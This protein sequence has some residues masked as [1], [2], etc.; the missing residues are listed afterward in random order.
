MEN[1]QA[2]SRARENK[3]LPKQWNYQILLNFLCSFPIKPLM[4]QLDWYEHFKNYLKGLE[5]SFKTIK[6][7]GSLL[8]H[9]LDNH[10]LPVDKYLFWAKENYK[11]PI[12]QSNFFKETPISQEM[13][14]RWATHYQ[15]SEECLPVAEWDGVLIVACLQPPQDFPQKVSFTLV[16]ASHQDLKNTWAKLNTKSTDLEAPD[17]IDISALVK[18]TSHSDEISIESLGLQL[19]ADS[20]EIL[21]LDEQIDSPLESEVLEGIFDE[22]TE[23]KISPIQLKNELSEGHPS[24]EQAKIEEIN[25]SNVR[26]LDSTMRPP[27]VKVSS[28]GENEFALEKLV[29]SYGLN[30][31]KS[32]ECVFKSMKKYFDKSLILTLDENETHLKVFASDESFSL[33]KN[34]E[35]QIP[36]GVPS[37]FNIVHSTIKP[38]HG[39]VSTNQINDKFF[40]SWNES[41]IPSHV[42]I[43]PLVYNKQLVGMIMGFAEKAGYTRESL[44][45][46]E[47]VSAEFISSL[48]EA[49]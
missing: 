6:P 32:T 11:F 46:A 37:I 31:N 44:K 23:V 33:V 35:L 14:A 26:K 49:A 7:H 20:P 40:E 2:L 24:E 36:L 21:A 10:F 3:K 17:G 5:E 18:N 28:S 15:W 48:E 22:S 19:S 4:D 25:F 12:L 39:Y 47:K 30:L 13:F 34:K 45:L 43:T 41:K 8:K 29:A 27:H 9:A 1:I 38:F 42:T 16:L